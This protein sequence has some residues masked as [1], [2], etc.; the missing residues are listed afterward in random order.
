M[1]N[2]MAKNRMAKKNQ[3]RSKKTITRTNR[4][5]TLRKISRKKKVLDKVNLVPMANPQIRKVRMKAT[6]L[7]T[8]RTV[9]IA[10][11]QNRSQRPALNRLRTITN[12]ALK[13]TTNL[14]ALKT[15]LLAKRRAVVP[16][17]GSNR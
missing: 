15:V 8:K 9:A 5:K 11:I 12:Q 13:L 17:R 7:Q 14:L 3:A 1:K 16:Q 4:A 6:F 10:I 2:L